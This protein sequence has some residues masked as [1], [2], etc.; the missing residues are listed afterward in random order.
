MN[1]NN[2]N[3]NTNNINN[4]NNEPLYIKCFENINDVLNTFKFSK[5]IP[6]SFDFLSN[7]LIYSSN[8]LFPEIWKNKNFK[9]NRSQIFY[10]RPNKKTKFY[11]KNNFNIFDENNFFFPLKEFYIKTS[12]SDLFKNIDE[13]NKI[14]NENKNN[15]ENKNNENIFFKTW[16]IFTIQNQH[17]KNF[18]PYTT[19][20]IFIFLKEIFFKINKDENNKNKFVLIEDVENNVH[21]KPELLLEILNKEF[22]NKYNNENK[23]IIKCKKNENKYYNKN[24]HY[25]K[26][27]NF[28]YRK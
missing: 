6:N 18:G 10:E 27:N 2:N 8:N 16:K 25:K 17:I 1:I 9:F 24:F 11:N 23:K 5:I 13:F 28:Y 21:Y 12:N 7:D 14:N 3:D 4:N 22:E 26:K 15:F 20:T 19:E